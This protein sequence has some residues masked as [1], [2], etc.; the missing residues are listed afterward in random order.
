MTKRDPQRS[1][2]TSWLAQTAALLAAATDPDA[3][4]ADLETLTDAHLDI[5]IAAAHSAHVRALKLALL[6]FSEQNVARLTADMAR[7]AG[8]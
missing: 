1:V 6:R 2:P 8:A 7:D 5:R 3:P 4:D